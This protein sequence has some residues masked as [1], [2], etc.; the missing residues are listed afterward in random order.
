M[1]NQYTADIIDDENLKP[2]V[3]IL[4]G[5]GMKLKIILQELELMGLKVSESSLK[6]RMRSWGFQRNNTM[7]E[8][9]EY[10]I[11][12][13]ITNEINNTNMNVGYRRMRAII[14]VKYNLFASKYFIH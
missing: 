11:K 1:T 2:I 4:F 12:L 5:L 3:R 13:A 6:R 7:N 8:D 10:N 14:R 9:L